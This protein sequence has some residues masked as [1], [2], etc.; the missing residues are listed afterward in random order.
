MGNE[1]GRWQHAKRPLFICGSYALGLSLG[2]E[3]L[4]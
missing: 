1:H 4:L 3:V 2:S